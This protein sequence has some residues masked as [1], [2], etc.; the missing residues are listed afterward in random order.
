MPPC[1][2]YPCCRTASKM[3]PG[4]SVLRVGV[5][6]PPP[7]SLWLCCSSAC[8]IAGALPCQCL[9]PSHAGELLLA[10]LQQHDSSDTIE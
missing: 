7:Q 1:L 2:Q 6:L 3:W 8:E 10:S 4:E 9:R 5:V